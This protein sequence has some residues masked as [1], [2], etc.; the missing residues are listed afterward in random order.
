MLLTYINSANKYVVNSDLPLPAINVTRGIRTKN[1]DLDSNSNSNSS[2]TGELPLLDEKFQIISISISKSPKLK[3]QCFIT[4][5]TSD[6]ANAFQKRFESEE[7]TI[8]G[9]AVQVQLARRDS[10]TALFAQEDK[11]KLEKVLKVRSLQKLIAKDSKK[12]EE[13]KLKRKLRRVRA[14][15][16]NKDFNEEQVR[17][18]IEDMKRAKKP[19][20]ATSKAPSTAS[21]KTEKRKVVEIDENPPNKILLVQNLPSGVTQADVVALFKNEGLVEVRLVGIRNLAFVEYDDVENASVVRNRLGP[22][23]T[24]R[25]KD[26]SIGFAK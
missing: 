4:F 6:A 25:D 12:L 1:N 18:I 11:T 16:R 24:W 14:K 3:N 15:L 17:Q 2:S 26:I 19:P 21:T 10:I 8:K 20:T 5:L 23:H 7:L 13:K 9:H 22:S